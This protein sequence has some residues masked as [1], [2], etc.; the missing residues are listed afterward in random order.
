M[1]ILFGDLF[2]CDELKFCLIFY[3]NVAFNRYWSVFEEPKKEEGFKEIVTIEWI[4]KF[5][6]SKLEQLFKQRS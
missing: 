5:E 4:P 2:E 1:S 6:N 3:S